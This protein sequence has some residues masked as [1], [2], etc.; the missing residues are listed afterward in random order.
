MKHLLATASALTLATLAQTAAAQDFDLGEIV[1]FSNLSET[2]AN[3]SGVTTEIIDSDTLATDGTVAVAD[4]LDALPG[5]SFT[6]N[7][8]T[9]ATTTLRLRGLSGYYVGVRVDGI[10]VTDPASAQ[11]QFNWGGMNT[12][13][14]SRVE[15]LKGSQSAIYGSEA[16]G[17]VINMTTAR[18]TED[19]THVSLNAEVGSYKTRSATGTITHRSDRGELALTLSRFQTDGFSHADENAGNTE[20][21]G[22]QSTTAILSGAYQASDAVRLGFSVLFQ[23]SE[24]GND[25]FPAPT[26]TFADTTDE[27][28]AKRIGGRIF[29]EIE[30][31]A[32]SH[33]FA[34]SGMRTER[35]YPTGFSRMFTGERLE[36]DYKGVADLGGA[37]LAFGAATS[38]E[39]FTVDTTTGDARIN[40]VFAEYQRG[41]TD[42]VDFALS[43]RHDDHSTFGGFTSGR[44]A[45][46]WR[47]AEGTVVRASIGNGFRAPSLYELFGPY[48]SATLTPEES[49]SAELGVEKTYANGARVQATA[50]YTEIDDLIQWAGTGYGQVAGTSETKGFELA[51]DI[52]LSDNVTLFG[53]FTYTDARDR[54]GTR[55]LRVPTHDTVV[56]VNARIGNRV[57]AV[58]TLQN[59]QGLTD[60][61]G[62][63]PSYTVANATVSYE[64]SGNA[65][66]YVRVENLFD[67]EYQVINGYGTSDRAAYF[68]IRADF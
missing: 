68:G 27:E 3:R 12:A 55:L 48:G 39:E 38:L 66:A 7:G 57:E 36:L 25:G 32:I 44:A 14:L 56:G 30:T 22:H 64:I 33:T 11:N 20:A 50:F 19:G 29:A 2:A 40:S 37:R 46:S 15:V 35:E 59:V 8:S 26:Y 28:L 5:V 10:D 42:N 62:K 1:V 34:V 41:L 21:D 47:P 9:G 16:I 58:A 65:E 51:T 61:T 49:V 63:M 60:L 23:D 52:P 53:S 17:G 54:S 18:A 24:T 67:K 4:K 13:G 31:G 6:Q 43:A 45:L